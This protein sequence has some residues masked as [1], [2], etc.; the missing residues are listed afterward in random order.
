MP[1]SDQVTC[2]RYMACRVPR[3]EKCRR[4]AK[5]TASPRRTRAVSDALRSASASNTVRW[6]SCS[7]LCPYVHPNSL[8][9]SPQP[10][11]YGCGCRLSPSC[12]PP[13]P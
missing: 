5:A 13:P 8:P 6:S 7:T 10:L 3:L 1:A 4:P 2:L 9:G 12:Q 11:S